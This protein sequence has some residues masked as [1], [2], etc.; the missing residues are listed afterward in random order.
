MTKWVVVGTLLATI[1]GYIR[2]TCYCALGRLFT[3]EMSIRDDH[4]LVTDG[5]YAWVRH[6]GYTGVLSTFIGMG[7]WH[8]TKVSKTIKTDDHGRST[9]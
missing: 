7:I 5:P 2:W 1:G 8:A 4:T 6:P 9:Y 3:F